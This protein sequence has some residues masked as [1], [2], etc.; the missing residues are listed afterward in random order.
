M[1]PDGQRCIMALIQGVGSL[2][3]CPQCLIPELKQGEPSVSVP[4][5]TE[6]GT[7]ATLEEARGKERAGDK[8]D[9]LKAAGLRDVDVRPHFYYYCSILL[10]TTSLTECILE[11]QK[12][13]PTCRAIF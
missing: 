5:Q 11:D 10:L 6:A 13:R 12:L 4:L 1:F 7:R 2:F 8:E 9:I 3:P